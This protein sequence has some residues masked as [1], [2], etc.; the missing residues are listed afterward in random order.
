MPSAAAAIA[1]IY[2]MK[3]ALKQQRMAFLVSSSSSGRKLPS[4]L[5]QH[6]TGTEERDSVSYVS[7]KSSK[8]NPLHTKI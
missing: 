1:A 8:L 6:L 3:K 5:D 7:K 2:K 4:K